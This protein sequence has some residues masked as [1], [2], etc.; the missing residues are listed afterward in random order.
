MLAV[1]C[2]AVC[3]LP[4]RGVAQA[5]CGN[6]VVEPNED[7][8]DGG[9]C[10]G[11]SNAGQACTADDQC[12][13]NGVCDAGM[14][15]GMSCAGDADCQGGRCLHCKPF[16]GDGCAANCTTER[17]VVLNLLPGQ[18][19][20]GGLAPGTSGAV[21][22]GAL[23]V[24]L[25]LQGQQILT[26]GKERN[27]EIPGVIKADSVYL[28]RVAIGTVGCACVRGVAAK[29]CGGT[30]FEADGMT[31]S[32]DCSDGFGPGASICPPDKPCAFLHGPGNSGSGVIGCQ[33]L[34]PVDFSYT[35]DCNGTTGGTAGNPEITLS[36]TGGPGSAL[37]FVSSAIGTVFGQCTG[38]GP[39]YG[40]DGEFC[41]DDDPPA[42]R[43]VPAT[44]PTTTSMATGMVFNANDTPGDVIGPYSA[45]GLEFTCGAVSAG[46]V[47]EASLVGAFTLCAQP[48]FGDI[49][50]TTAF[51][52]GPQGSPLPTRTP[53]PTATATA[54]PGTA[55]CCQ[56]AD[57]PAA[58]QPPAADGCGACRAVYNAACD[59]SGLCIAFTPTP[60]VTPTLA[61]SFTPTASPTPTE[62]PPT[63]TISPT[64]TPPACVGD[65][66][67]DGA[68]TVDEILLAVNVALGTASVDVCTVADV[69]H[70]QLITVDEILQAVNNALNGCDVHAASLM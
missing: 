58:C 12:V 66:G 62:V 40:L 18:V 16:G 32:T 33:Q 41:T 4:E 52:A 70:D 6:G 54:T 13:G 7:C 23:T 42:A 27:G 59:A 5:T 69:N 46:F 45:T 20:N 9:L 22:H 37:V 51:V 55:D 19:H 35:Q 57:D 63:P 56:C 24:A 64:A 8:D 34:A 38:S 65:C 21:V 25:P 50:V 17:D 48:S 47:E 29:T 44:L 67:R 3:S 43:G 31:L 1:A 10:V 68:V 15:P 49:A 61:P 39:E 36:G 2:L 30:L 14:R 11:G 53:T 28:P 60:S 26:V